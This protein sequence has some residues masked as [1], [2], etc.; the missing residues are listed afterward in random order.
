MDDQIS[1]NQIS[2]KWLMPLASYL[3]FKYYKSWSE[4]YKSFD[5]KR[6]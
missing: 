3:G 4:F 5:L 1:K 6:L 2:A